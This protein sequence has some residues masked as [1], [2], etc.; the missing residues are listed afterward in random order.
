M[1]TITI[2]IDVAE[3]A[4]EALGNF[5]SDHGWSDSDMQAMDNLD[6]YIARHRA[7]QA[8]RAKLAKPADIADEMSAVA[9]QFAHRLALDLEC[10]LAD[11]S[12]TWYDTA[13]STL[14]AY[15]KAMNAIHERESPTFMGE[16]VLRDEP[17]VARY[18]HPPTPA[19]HDEPEVAA[20]K[21]EIERLKELADSE[22]TRTV[23]YLRRARKAE[24][25]IEQ[26][27]KDAERYRWLTTHARTTSEHWGGRWSIVIDGPAPE[28]HGCKDAL[29]EAIDA[30]IAKMERD[31]AR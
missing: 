20:L 11:Y 31:T 19:W 9:D 4:S 2:P 26:L 5:V 30:A 7:N 16:P 23:E 15:R 28:R 12:G 17:S 8:A 24:A 25:E 3:A 22:G 14:G 6:A 29:D 18:L 13:I 1:T 21:S 10:V 27:R